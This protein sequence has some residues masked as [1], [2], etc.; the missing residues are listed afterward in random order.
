MTHKVT[1]DQCIQ[2][3]VM[4]AEQRLAAAEQRYKQLNGKECCATTIEVPCDIQSS[5]GSG[6]QR[7]E[8]LLF[9]KAIGDG[10]RDLKQQKADKVCVFVLNCL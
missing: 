2:S 6:D 1:F 4:D 8:L 10:I 5:S 3:V 7:K 9:I